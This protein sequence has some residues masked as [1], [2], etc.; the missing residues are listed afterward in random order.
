MRINVLFF[1]ILR[2]VTGLREDSIE[3][4]DGG[5]ASSVFDDYAARF[6]QLG[7]MSRSIVLAV[8]Q[9]FCAPGEELSDGDELAMLP[10]V[11]GGSD[12]GNYFALTREKID[13]AAIARR[14]L[15]GEDGAIVTFEGVTRNNTNGRPTRFLEYE[16]Y[17]AMA[18]MTMA[19]IGEEIA[20]AHQI[21]RIAMVHR[22]GRV[23]IGE[24]SVVVIATAPH[25]RPAFDA[26]LEG[27]NRLKKTVPVWKKEYFA[28]GEVWV[29]G[30]WD[31]SVKKARE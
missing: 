11:S 10:P 1:G 7:E 29:D 13:A 28:D 9:R 26:A 17:E 8:N 27:I 4:P 23:E 22:L 30:E 6:P 18:L 21:S 15:R 2:D 25:R 3:I 24:T 20:K 19:D 12:R 14:I 5:L 16:C 31:D